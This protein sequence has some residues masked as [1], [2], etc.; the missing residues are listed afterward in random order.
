MPMTATPKWPTDHGPLHTLTELGI[1]PRPT[2][3]LRWVNFPKT[4]NEDGVTLWKCS[5]RFL[6]TDALRALAA[7]SF[8]GYRIDVLATNG[9]ECDVRIR[10][11]TSPS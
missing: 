11:E 10:K 6:F 2:A 8:E 5:T 4:V 1:I 9:G 3:H 7:L